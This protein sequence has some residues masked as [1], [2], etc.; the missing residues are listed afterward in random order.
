MAPAAASPHGL[1]RDPLLPHPP[2][3]MAGGAA[4]ALAVHAALALALAA[5]VSWRTS[6]TEVVAS[7]ELW[8]A[9]PQVA[10]PAA[11]APPPAPPVQAPTPAPAPPPEPARASPRAPDIAVERER[12]REREKERRAAEDAARAK[13]K[14][15]EREKDREREKER[16][17]AKAKAEAEAQE[18]RLAAQRAENLR[19]MMGQAGSAAAP[20]TTAGTAARDAAPSA[21]YI[22][23]L[24]ATI[25]ANIVYTGSPPGNPAAEVEVRAGPSGTILSRR[26]VKSSGVAEWDEAVLRAI[27]R[28][29]ALPRDTDGRVPPVLL[30]SFRLRE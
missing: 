4:A 17:L 29:A 19:R 16:A 30:V 18:A 22:G 25:R 27:D 21:G 2:G 9:V 23:R 3:G 1:L 6:S 28:T 14:E 8:A 5:A 24:V 10:A 11:A 15:R 7:A 26:L 20:S 13:E 12:E